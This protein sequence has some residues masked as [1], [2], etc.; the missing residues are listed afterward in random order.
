[1]NPSNEGALDTATESVTAE[2][3]RANG[4]TGPDGRF[5]QGKDGMGQ[6]EFKIGF[7]DKVTHKVLDIE[8]SPALLGVCTRNRPLYTELT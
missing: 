8:V 3:A 6:Y 1:M 2:V 7:D 5:F 4:G